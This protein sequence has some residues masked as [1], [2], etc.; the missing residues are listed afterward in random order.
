MSIGFAPPPVASLSDSGLR[1]LLCVSSSLACGDTRRRSSAT[2]RTASHHRRGGD[3]ERHTRHRRQ[4]AQRREPPGG[5]KTEVRG[6]KGD[7]GRVAVW[8][9]S[10]GCCRQADCA[11]E[12]SAQ[13]PLRDSR[14]PTRLEFTPDTIGIVLTYVPRSIS[15]VSSLASCSVCSPVCCWSPPPPQFPQS[16]SRARRL[17]L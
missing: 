7:G 11:P 2:D 6:G 5:E 14:E 9:W 4:H 13:C 1:V 10:R 15:S 16:H 17:L 8:R 12:R 3:T